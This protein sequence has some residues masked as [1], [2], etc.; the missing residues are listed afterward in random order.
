M[1]E[2]QHIHDLSIP[3]VLDV[4]GEW[5]L[6]ANARVC[7]TSM[8]AGPLK[9]RAI[10]KRHNSVLWET[11]WQNI[12]LPKFDSAF[13]FT[14][15]R[16]PWDRVCSAFFKCRDWS[17]TLENKINPE[18]EFT[19]WLECVLAKTW[20][21]VNFHFAEQ[22]PTAYCEGRQV[23]CVGRFERIAEDW[24]EIAGRIGVSS[25]L[26]SWNSARHGS[27]LD[28]YDDASRQ[29]VAELYQREIAAFGYEYGY[30][31]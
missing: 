30:E 12:I 19:E 7:S 21:S 4:L 29:I 2:Q 9:P 14:V 3:P 1:T 5:I 20:P 25:E 10:R 11:V 22:Y 27:Y 8:V 18:W 24:P 28:H 13:I 26:P 16:N 6:C 15:V 31:Q 23:S 17:R